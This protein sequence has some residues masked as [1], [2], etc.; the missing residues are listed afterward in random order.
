[1]AGKLHPVVQHGLT[2]QVQRCGESRSREATA[3]AQTGVEFI[4]IQIQGEEG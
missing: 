1:M 3:E 4:F 2:S